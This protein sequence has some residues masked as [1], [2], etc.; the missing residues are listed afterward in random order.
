[1]LGKRCRNGGLVVVLGLAGVGMLVGQEQKAALPVAEVPFGEV[2]G[3]VSC[4]DTNAPARFAVVTLEP[5]PGTRAKA[6][7]ATGADA[8]SNATAMTD[9]EGRFQLDKVPVGRYFVLASL[10]GYVNPLARF[11]AAQLQ[12]MSEATAKELAKLVLVISVEAGTAANVT[13][14]LEHASEV[15]GTVLY[16][17]GS[18]AVGLHVE[19]LRKDSMGELSPVKSEMIDGLGE[20]GSHATTDDRGHYRMIGTPPGEYTVHLTMPMSQVSVSGLL[21][22]TGSSVSVNGDEGGRL[23]LY[24]GNKFRKKDAVFTKVG[25]GETVGGQDFTIPV[26]GLHSVSGTV[27]AISDGKGVSGGQVELLYADDREVAKTT[28]LGDE[29]EF[30]FVFVPEGNYVLR[31]RGAENAEATRNQAYSTNPGVPNPTADPDA[32]GAETP[33]VVDT[34]VSGV[35]LVVKEAPVKKAAAQ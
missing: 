33:V 24:T 28:Q 4:A 29:G 19:L 5:M 20:F 7:P 34:D 6:Y 3:Q 12:E 25:D 1:M 27:T 18:P 8:Q 21:G 26:V 13:V 9:L 10:P 31:M 11:D 30:T 16:D 2:S 14:R 23:S 22:G 35:S 32:T 15:S 17:D